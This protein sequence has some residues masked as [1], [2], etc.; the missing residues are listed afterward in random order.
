MNRT[1]SLDLL[2]LTP[3]EYGF[4]EESRDA[5]QRRKR[6]RG[7]LL[8]LFVTVVSAMAFWATL[9]TCEVQRYA[10]DLEQSNDLLE[11]KSDSL[12]NASDEANKYADVTL[13]ADIGSNFQNIFE[14]SLKN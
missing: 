13:L 7:F 1:G 5:I 9:Q 12:K 8:T 10:K 11:L 14:K 3:E 4:V 2:E 6:R